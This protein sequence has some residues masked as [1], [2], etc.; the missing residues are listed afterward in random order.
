MC[1]APECVKLK[2]II[3]QTEF[4]LKLTKNK[5]TVQGTVFQRKTMK[6][7]L[8]S[9]Q[10]GGQTVGEASSILVLSSDQFRCACYV[11]LIMC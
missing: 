8:C 9:D 2:K 10:N 7:A 6:S 1:T 4:S 11:C 5:G 3:L